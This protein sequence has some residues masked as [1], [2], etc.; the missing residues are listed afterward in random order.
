MD[1]E[2]WIGFVHWTLTFIMPSRSFVDLLVALCVFFYLFVCSY[3]RMNNFIIICRFICQSV[4]VPGV[5]VNGVLVMNLLKRCYE[6]R[7]MSAQ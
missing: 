7:K 3:D 6:R 4:F 5:N 1:N 2:F